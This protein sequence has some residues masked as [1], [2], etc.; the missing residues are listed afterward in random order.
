[1]WPFKKKPEEPEQDS[2][3][4]IEADRQMKELQYKMRGENPEK[5]EARKKYESEEVKL[6]LDPRSV[7]AIKTANMMSIKEDDFDKLS[8]VA[9]QVNDQ[10]D[11][12]GIAGPAFGIGMAGAVAMAAQCVAEAKM[13]QEA[14]AARRTAMANRGQASLLGTSFLNDRERERGD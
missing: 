9:Q 10:M 6:D 11:R 3:K 12:V 14:A 13:R 4:K 1:M 8:M 5:A 7:N 2:Q